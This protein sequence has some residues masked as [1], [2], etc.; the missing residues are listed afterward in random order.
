MEVNRAGKYR[1]ELSA[2]QCV[3]TCTVNAFYCLDM[4]KI[5]W[6]KPVLKSNNAPFVHSQKT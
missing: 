3:Q 2:M 1:Y 5:V 4:S 6:V